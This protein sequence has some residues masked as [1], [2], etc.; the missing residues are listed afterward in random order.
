MRYKRNPSGMCMICPDKIHNRMKSAKYCK[1][2]AKAKFYVSQRI[3]AIK[4]N[5]RKEHPNF[6]FEYTLKIKRI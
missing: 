3:Y 5:F 2:C 4:T 6:R 1:A